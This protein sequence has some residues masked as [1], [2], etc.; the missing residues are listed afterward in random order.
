VILDGEKGKK[1]TSRRYL[2]TEYN[3][4]VYLMLTI[5]QIQTALSCNWLPAL[6]SSIKQ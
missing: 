4:I 6:K 5:Q 3:L 1:A 2:E